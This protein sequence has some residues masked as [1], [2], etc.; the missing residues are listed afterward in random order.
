MSSTASRNNSVVAGMVEA[1]KSKSN[2]NKLWAAI[3]QHHDE[4]NQ[5]YAA[6]YSPGSSRATS[7]RASVSSTPRASI[8]EPRSEEAAKQPTNLSKHWKQLKTKVVEHHRGVNA[9]YRAA[10]GAGF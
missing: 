7:P 9:A 5:A 8:E 3:K 1:P 10:Y 6:F 2:S 4:M